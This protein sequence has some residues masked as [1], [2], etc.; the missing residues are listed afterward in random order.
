MNFPTTINWDGLSFVNKVKYINELW[1]WSVEAA[2]A[3]SNGI[4]KNMVLGIDIG[5]TEFKGEVFEAN[6]QGAIDPNKVFS[7]VENSAKGLTSYVNTYFLMLTTAIK[8]AAERG[9]V[10]MGVGIGTP[11]RIL[12]PD[13][14]KK[15]YGKEA[16]VNKS[17]PAFLFS[18]GNPRSDHKTP[19]ALAGWKAPRN[20]IMAADSNPAFTL[21]K[22]DFD[23]VNIW[24]VIQRFTPFGVQ[25]SVS[26]DAGV[27]AIGILN[28]LIA[29]GQA[30]RVE[31][32]KIIYTG[33]GTGLGTAAINTDGEL[34]TDGHFQYIKMQCRS[35]DK[36]DRM[37]FESV[38]ENKRDIY[39]KHDADPDYVVP[40]DILSGTAIERLLKTTFNRE[41]KGR[42]FDTIYS[43]ESN[44]ST[45]KQEAVEILKAVGRYY[46][47]YM[48]KIYQGKLEMM[49]PKAQWSE[50]DIEH[51]KE[52]ESVIL[53]GS[54][55]KSPAFSQ[56]V[57]KE[58]K[59]VMKV[60]GIKADKID[61]IIPEGIEVSPKLAAAQTL[62]KNGIGMN[63]EAKALLNAMVSQ[64]E[65]PKTVGAA[66]RA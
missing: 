36:Y 48:T 13:N 9:G 32:K 50:A 46:G 35:D 34:V 24:S 38:P 45:E 11:G 44:N 60:N 52:F 42:E 54:W 30:N 19:P 28:A 63:V 27:Y 10:I 57:L 15:S 59:E 22:G 6:N 26:N 61:F 56:V 51:V 8:E 12:N 3:N 49:D 21:T 16:E 53:G 31:G 66:Q 1:A 39:R 62:S 65:E 4:P 43:D 29:D 58:T 37:V 2:K 23:W 47:D 64:I 17:L 40:E 55:S 33:P 18:V 7:Q 41:I 14:V 20:K 5:G 25:A